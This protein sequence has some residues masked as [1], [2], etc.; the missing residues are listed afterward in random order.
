MIGMVA[1]GGRN[2]LTAPATEQTDGGVAAGCEDLWGGAA[3][4]SARVFAK[5]DVPDVVEPVFD[6]PVTSPALRDP[7][8]GCPFA[9]ETRDRVFD[10]DRS[11]SLADGR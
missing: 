1:K 6:A 10:F 5:S 7:L 4:D 3:T 2:V 8:G 11:L 9:T